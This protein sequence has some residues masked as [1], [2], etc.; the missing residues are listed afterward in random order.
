MWYLVRHGSLFSSPVNFT[1]RRVEILKALPLKRYQKPTP[2]SPIREWVVQTRFLGVIIEN[3]A[4]LR[5]IDRMHKNFFFVD[6]L[7]IG[8]ARILKS[9]STSV[10]KELLPLMDERLKDFNLNDNQVDQLAASYVVHHAKGEKSNYPI[11]TIV[12]NPFHRLVSVYLDIFNSNNQEFV[13]RTYLFG[14]LKQD[15]SFHEF[16]KTLTLIPSKLRSPHFA[17]QTEIISVC[18]GLNQINFFRL[19]KDQD[20]LKNFLL[21]FNIHIGHNNRGR[22]YDYRTYYDRETLKLVHEM[23]MSDIEE[24]GYVE[25]CNIL[26]NYVNELYLNR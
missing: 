1:Q 23:Y 15:M 6:S 2:Y 7:K 8:Y 12:R 20:Q 26:T 9:A 25:E 10:L 16:V 5:R 14:L 22:E 3:I 4:Y 24:L 21:K 11:F 18:G 13:F 19:E 17:G